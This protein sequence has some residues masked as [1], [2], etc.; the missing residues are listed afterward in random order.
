MCISR[1]DQVSRPS[2]FQ[3][4]GA[5]IAKNIRE[6]LEGSGLTCGVDQE[7]ASDDPEWETVLMPWLTTKNPY[8][9]VIPPFPLPPVV[10]MV[11]NELERALGPIE[12]MR[13]SLGLLELK[14]KGL[15]RVQ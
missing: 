14:V 13:S 1:R 11:P 10:V 12:K 7:A 4:E 6:Q 8:L 2:L 15:A 3:V 5:L 9:H